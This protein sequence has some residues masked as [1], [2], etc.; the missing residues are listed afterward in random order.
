MEGFS[1]LYQL[2]DYFSTENVCEEYLAFTRWGEN[3]ECPYC[4][5]KRVNS[6]KGKTKRYKCY[7]CRKQFSVRVGTIFHNS[8]LPLRKWFIAIHL[9]ASSKGISS[10]QLARELN[11]SQESAWFMLHRIRETFTQSERKLKKRKVEIDETLFGGLEKNKHK[12]KKTPNN[13]G[14]STKTKAGILGIIERGENKQVYAIHVPRL[15]GNTIIPIIESKVAKTSTVY[16]DEYR[17]YRRLRAN[18]THKFVNHSQGKY[19]IADAHTNTIEGFW[20]MLK[21]NLVNTYHSISKYHLQRYINEVVFKYNNNQIERFD[22][23]L[24]K[25]MHVRLEYQQL[26]MKK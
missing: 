4:N 21:K 15:D 24:K 3:P 25:A 1:S 8:K 12:D 22:T 13:Q 20:S 17:P 6:L 7:G 11:I 10:H 23:V 18:Y 16:T 2:L 26:I 5:S 9:C 19:V 14:R